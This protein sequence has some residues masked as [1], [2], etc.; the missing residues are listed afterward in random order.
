MKLTRKNLDASRGQSTI[1][2]PERIVHLGL[3]AFHRAH[4]AW[5]TNSVD[6]NKQWGIIAFTGTKPD[7]ARLLAE[8][9]GLYTL[10]TRGALQDDFQVIEAI[11]RVEDG[12]DSALLLDAL[13][14]PDTSIVTLTI[15]EN[16]YGFESRGRISTANPPD[17]L[18][19]LAKGLEARRLRCGKGLAV[20]SCDN[21]AAN[22][23]LLKLA[24]QD[25]F[26]AMGSEANDWLDQNVSFVS[27][28]VDRIT[29]RTTQADIQTVLMNTGMQDNSPVVTEEFSDWILEGSFPE[30]RPDWE[31]AGARFVKNI[32][33][34]ENR[35]LWLL[36][37]AHS[38]LSYLGQLRGHKTVSEAITDQDCIN[39]ILD[40]WHEAE[41]GL[42][43]VELELTKY[44]E[45]L[46]GRFANARIE[47][48][49]SQIEIDG[50]N[51][52]GFRI[53]PVAKNEIASGR[54]GAASATVFAAWINFVKSKNDIFDSRLTE[55]NQ[56]KS[57]AH[58]HFAKSLIS[59][60]DDELSA[61]N[62][63]VDLVKEKMI[64]ISKA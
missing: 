10:V 30:G 63:F 36:N 3:G 13:S 16:G 51:K 1:L 47:H 37:G 28:S 54:T 40:F 20:V 23:T 56:A 29:P 4:Q 31:R 62:G 57:S 27:T 55:I 6:L 22:G 50:S 44:K 64:E 59:L 43:E 17:M 35:K 61:N 21:M 34:F 46:L 9:E 38:L 2:R 12:N 32:E 42:D 58:D 11:V 26:A 15:T 8:Q 45:S 14:S 39:A 33:P 48:L 24:M 53:A 5:Y 19:K 49:L 52:L 18:V 7:M 41:S 60:V 25:L